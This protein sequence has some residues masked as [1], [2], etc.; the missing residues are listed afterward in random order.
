MR[1]LTTLKF[2]IASCVALAVFIG[3]VRSQSITLA[4]GAGDCNNFAA[5]CNAFEYIAVRY[6]VT[7]GSGFDPSNNY[8]PLHFR[9]KRT[10]PGETQE[11][12]PAFHVQGGILKDHAL[13]V[14]NILGASFNMACY[15]NV[16]NDF[17]TYSGDGLLYY[18]DTVVGTVSTISGQAAIYADPCASPSGIKTIFF[19]VT[20]NYGSAEGCG[21]CE[22]ARGCTPGTGTARMGSLDYQVSLGKDSY[23]TFH[24]YL[25]LSAPGPHETLG[26]PSALSGIM[27][28]N[29]EV[30]RTNS[31]LRQVRT[32]KILADTVT[33]NSYAY[34]LR[35]YDTNNV[36]PAKTNGVWVPTGSPFRTITIENPDGA[37]ASTRLHITE[38]QGATSQLT[39]YTWDRTNKW[40]L[41][42]PGGLRRET[43]VTTTNATH[44]T[45]Q[46]SILSTNNTLVYQEQRKFAIHDFGERLTEKIVDTNGA[47]LTNT[48]E[49]YTNGNKGNYTQLKQI[50][51]P[52]GYWERYEY[53]ETYRETN[54]VMAF[55]NSTNNAPCQPS[56]AAHH[57]V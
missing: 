22:S 42:H 30:I 35:F 14:T 40:T 10:R 55:L 28:T 4:K 19:H 44:R 43:L 6:V 37:T 12:A 26:H 3:E 1:I 48:W 8:G 17:Y 38:T 5:L 27:S 15:N 21:S 51:T 32:Q 13:G 50:T 33:S 34:D 49:Y 45:E 16:G 36:S 47:R 7:V 29:C 54:R 11:Y 52:S 18:G 23:G 56:P 25:K 2:P 53:D 46:Y 57:T 9:V 20:V 41:D 31:V 24:S 39:T